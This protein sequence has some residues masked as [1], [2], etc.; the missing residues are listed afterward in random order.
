MMYC[1]KNKQIHTLHVLKY[2]NCIRSFVMVRRLKIWAPYKPQFHGFSV[3]PCWPW[4]FLGAFIN[5]QCPCTLHHRID[6][7]ITLP[8][9]S[10]C[11]CPVYPIPPQIQVPTSQK[12]PK[13][14]SKINCNTNIQVTFY[15]CKCSFRGQYIPNPNKAL[16]RGIPSILPYICIKLDSP[17]IFSR[18]MIHFSGVQQTST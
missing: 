14:P 3:Y 9:L 17:E 18:L 11:L 13:W 7:L 1:D 6:P 12:P 16:L 10:A 4:I 8:E 15:K 5:C 2:L